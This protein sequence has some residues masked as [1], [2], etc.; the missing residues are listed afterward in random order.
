[1]TGR[2]SAD[3][4]ALDRLTDFLVE[5]I[6]DAPDDDILAETREEGVEPGTDAVRLRGLFER[7]VLDV[8]KQR[9]LAAKAAVKAE[10]SIVQGTSAVRDVRDARRRLQS[11]LEQKEAFPALT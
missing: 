4:E 6:L 10:R 1:M 5:D 9:L 2:K 7:A 3:R 8:N 11:M